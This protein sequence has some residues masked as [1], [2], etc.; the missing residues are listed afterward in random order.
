M[1][2]VESCALLLEDDPL[3]NA[4]Y[5]SVLNESGQAEMDAAIMDGRDLSAGSVAAVRNIANLPS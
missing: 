3:F 2:A 4:D 5:G 1:E